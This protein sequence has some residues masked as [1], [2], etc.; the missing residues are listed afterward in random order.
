[1]FESESGEEVYAG[2]GIEAFIYYAGE[3]MTGWV[4]ELAVEYNDRMFDLGNSKGQCC[5]M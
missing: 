1:V 5:A 4:I 2:R 3:G